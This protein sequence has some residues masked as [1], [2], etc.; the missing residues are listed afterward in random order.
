[1][2]VCMYVDLYCASVRALWHARRHN[3]HTH[4][5]THMFL[6]NAVMTLGAD[7]NNDEDVIGDDEAPRKRRRKRMKPSVRI[8]PSL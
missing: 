4:T 6:F 1:M 3:T 8:F 2:Y 5:H 7:D